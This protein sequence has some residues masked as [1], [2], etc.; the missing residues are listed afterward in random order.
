MRA[1][2]Q[3][4]PHPRR[5]R[6]R[7]LTGFGLTLPALV[8]VFA[9]MVYPIASLVVLS[10]SDYSPLRSTARTFAGLANY[11]WLVGSDLVHQSI[12]V[13]V[14]FTAASLTIQIAVG[15]P[16]AVVPAQLLVA[17]RSRPRR[18]LTPLLGGAFLFALPPPAN[19]RAIASHT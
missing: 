10:V 7:W 11:A 4:R 12:W 9:V 6:A 5:G 15:L 3:A 18:L 16:I 17:P 8:F 19:S 2:R 13:T 1:M 14:V